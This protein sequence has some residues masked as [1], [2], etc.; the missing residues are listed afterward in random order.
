[1]KCSKFVIILKLVQESIMLR[2]TT[3]LCPPN[4]VPIAQGLWGFLVLTVVFHADHMTLQPVS[5]LR[6][7]C[8]NPVT[9]GHL[10]WSECVPQMFLMQWH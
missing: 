8:K 10:L 4:T 9:N 5:S 6:K 7:E 2:K 1:M 3:S